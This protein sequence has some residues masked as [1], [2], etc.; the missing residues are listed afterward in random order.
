MR[1]GVVLTAAFAGF[2]IAVC[3]A[4]WTVGTHAVARE[5]QQSFML[6]ASLLV[7]RVV[8]KQDGAPGLAGWV[9]DR[10]GSCGTVVLLHGRGS[11]KRAMVP[12]AKLLFETGYSVMLFDL[13]GH[14]E[15]DGNVRGFGYAE[16]QDASRILAFPRQRF[17]GHKVAAVGSSLGAAA[18]VFAAPQQ[19]ADAYVLEQLYATLRETTALRAPLAMLRD[20]QATVLLAQMPMRLGFGAAD[21]RTVDYIGTIDRPILLLAGSA[22]PFVDRT[23]TLA[24]KDAADA[25]LVWFDGARHVDLYGFDEQSYR[26]RVVPFLEKNLCRTEVN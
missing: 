3:A 20:V 23:Q 26:D 15:S 12:R 6:P 17:A 19:H 22:D 13:S 10:K 2:C 4:T 11:N 24:L 25:E 8:L 14:G 5:P 1:R 9:A 7:E 21:V 18:F 16:R